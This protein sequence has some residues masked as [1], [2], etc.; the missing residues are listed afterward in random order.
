MSKPALFSVKNMFEQ[1]DKK[2]ITILLIC[3][4]LRYN[5]FKILN[6][7]NKFWVL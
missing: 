2:I 5:I 7:K 1:T 4:M 3:H 6:K